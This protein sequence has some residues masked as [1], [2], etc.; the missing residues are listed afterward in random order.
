MKKSIC[1]ILTAMLLCMLLFGCASAESTETDWYL[2]KADAIRK[3]LV[4]LCA[5]TVYLS[6]CTPDEETLNLTAEWG[7]MIASEPLHVGKYSFSVDTLVVYLSNSTPDRLS[8]PAR[9]HLERNAGGSLL[10]MSC[11]EKGVSFLV[12]SSL[13]RINEGC[14]MPENFEPCVVLYEYEDICIGVVFTQ[15]GDGVVMANAGIC[16]EEIKRYCV[17][18]DAADGVL[19]QDAAPHSDSDHP[20]SFAPRSQHKK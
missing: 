20:A 5:D 16:T 18:T 6:A 15:Y 12:A 10:S 11:A 13:L 4:L 2:E 8:E 9:K 17:S 7:K 1:R 19:L 3:D 14:V